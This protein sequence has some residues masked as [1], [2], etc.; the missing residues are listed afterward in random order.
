MCVHARDTLFRVHVTDKLP[1]GLGPVAESV[2]YRGHGFTLGKE[3]I[4]H[5]PCTDRVAQTNPSS[6]ALTA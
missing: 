3:L 2:H 4:S 5:M 1:R 6:H